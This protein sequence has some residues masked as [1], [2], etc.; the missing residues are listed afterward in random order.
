MGRV[1]EESW[2]R[3]WWELYFLDGLLAGIQ[4]RESFKLWSVECTVPL[5]CEEAE[6][7]KGRIPEPRGLVEFDERYFIVNETGTGPKVFSSFAY[8]VEAIRILGQVL[9][10]VGSSSPNN[11]PTMGQQEL[12]TRLEAAEASLANWGLHLPDVKKELMKPAAAASPGPGGGGVDEM[13]F[14]AH[15]VINS[16]VPPP[17]PLIP[18]PT[19]T[20]QT[21]R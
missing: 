8:R 19:N 17:P 21:V 18:N 1:L 16:S 10:A 3:T 15:M 14:Q 20:Q 9:M 7:M 13:L 12:E 2:R 5:P 4:Q 6:Y 11:P